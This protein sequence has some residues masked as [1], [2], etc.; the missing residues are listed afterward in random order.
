MKTTQKDF[1][2]F[3][4]ECQRHV[5]LFGL[6]NWEIHYDWV[7]KKD[8]QEVEYV[9]AHTHREGDL[10]DRVTTV[11]LSKDWENEKVTREQ[12]AKIAKHEVMHVLFY[13]YNYLS[14]SRFAVVNS[15]FQDAEHEI[16]RVLEKLL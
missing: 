13:R 16:L 6:K 12:L 4:K 14:K 2:F 9:F 11:C 8:E 10:S 7:D 3:K 1:D 15:D 5:D